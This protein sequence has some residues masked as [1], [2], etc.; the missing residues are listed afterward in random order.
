M[1][2]QNELRSHTHNG[3]LVLAVDIGGTKIALAVVTSNGALLA[4]KIFP[5]PQAGPEYGI[6]LIISHLEALI[7]ESQIDLIRLVGIGI[8]I[9]AV[10][11]PGN[12]FIIWA[13][14]LAGWKNV[15]LR[16][17]LEKHFGL[18]VS[19]EYDGHTAVLGEWW[20]GAGKGY[21]S[22]VSVIIGTG[23][24]GGMVL[25][26]H[27]FRG[28]NRLAGAVGWFSSEKNDPEAEI[29]GRSVG[30]WEALIAGPGISRRVKKLLAGIPS[31]EMEKSKLQPDS[32]VKE[33]FSLARHGDVLALQVVQE[34]AVLMGLGLANII[35]LIDPEI[36]IL[37]G[38][39][40][41]NSTF[42]LPQIKEI[43]LQHAQPISAKSVEIVSSKLGTQAG[44]LGAAYG[45]LMRLNN[46]A[47]HENNERR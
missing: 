15:N 44:L 11:E 32:T 18:P 37:G 28:Q 22:V 46:S 12:D 21:Q 8:G 30:N 43:V 24:G 27:L 45:V 34:Q 40:G 2:L 19:V 36:V 1:S 14:N 10:L 7:Q 16:G 42:L 35:S 13:P 20:M 47:S 4:D 17:A 9:P 38:N 3:D 29:E 41:A 6:A 5:T 23:V 26:G 33:L 31:T 25:N 39:V